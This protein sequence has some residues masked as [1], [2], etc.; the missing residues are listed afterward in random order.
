MSRFWKIALIV[1]VVVVV[2]A[3]GFRLLHKPAPAGPASA[4]SATKSKGGKDGKDETPPVPVTVVPVV[5][6]N[7]P[8]YLTALG[9][10]QALNTVTVNPQVGGLL[11]S[12]DF[13][14][15]QPVKKGQVLAQIDPRTY[16]AAYDQALAKQH[17]DQA[18][19]DT[20][21]SNLSRNQDLITKGYISKQDLDTLRNTATQYQAAVAADAANIRDSQVQLAYTKVISPI[22]GLAG[23]RGV[24]PG[25]VITTSTAI[26]TLTQLQPINI[27]FTLPEQNLDMVR[28]AAT[29]D[30][31]ALQV[32]AL[33]RTDSHP[34]ASGG[35]LKVIDNQID[36]TTGTFRLKSEFPNAKNEL[37][38]GQFVNVQLLVN[39]VDGGLVIP[40]Q[41][42]Q[43]GPDGDYVYQVQAD[44][45]VKMQP[46][47]V[48]GEVGDSHVMIGSGLKAG[49]RVVT[50]GQFR[51]KPGSKVNA[52]KPGEVPAAPTAAELEKAK[53]NTKGGGRRH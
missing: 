32:T 3:V 48:A 19:L 13:T 27:M 21:K 18:L 6:Q 8:V 31:A 53:K 9:T 39:T 4:Q 46:V 52:L 49:D 2:A 17:Q 16:Q 14:E 35:V 37:W 24:D 38:P 28:A 12:L 1:L 26:V 25:N 41:A 50:E 45:T 42:V 20:A 15:G 5:K 47:V 43:R 11:L 51:L 34:I 44:S 40:A 10:V 23:I 29:R 22:D 7:V 33:D 30:S 36:T